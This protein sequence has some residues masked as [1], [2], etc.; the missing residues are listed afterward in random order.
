[1]DLWLKELGPSTELCKWFSQDLAKWKEFQVRYRKELR[2]ETGALTLLKQK[3]QK[4]TVTLMYGARVEEHKG[5]LLL[6]RILENH[7]Q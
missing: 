1:M 3:S 5:A 7:I 2:D 6:K 4:H